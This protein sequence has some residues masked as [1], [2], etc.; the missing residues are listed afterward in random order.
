MM[1]PHFQGQPQ[2]FPP[3]IRHQTASVSPPI[4]NGV[5]FPGHPAH[6][7]RSHTP[8]PAVPSRPGSRGDMRRMGPGMMSQP[9]GPHGPHPGITYMPTPPIYNPAA[10]N[11]SNLM[12]PQPG[13]YPFQPPQ[14]QQQP[15]M[16]ERRPSAPPAFNAHPPPQPMAAGPRPEPSPPQ[17]PHQLVPPHSIP[18]HMTS[19]QPSRRPLDPQPPPPVEPKP[20]APERPKAPLINTDIA[21]KK[22]SQRKSH[23]IFT[24]IE[25]NRSILSQHL[26]S[27]ASEPQSQPN[28]NRSQSADNGPIIRNGNLRLR[29]TCNNV[30]TCAIRRYPLFLTLLTLA[31]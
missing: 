29:R 3:H 8:Q 6:L 1:P 14:Q 2:S 13:P 25:E 10:G 19:P 23:S 4:P 28:A 18:P 9:V 11:H 26:A 16:E 24:P 21:I 15:Y 7:Q 5:P 20:E 22:I 31:V 17:P 30:P 27:F 12:P